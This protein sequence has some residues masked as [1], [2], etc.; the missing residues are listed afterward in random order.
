VLQ[1]TPDFIQTSETPSN[2]ESIWGLN[3]L[4]DEVPTNGAKFLKR[5]SAGAHNTKCFQ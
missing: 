1:V 4:F 2:V 3:N 5:E